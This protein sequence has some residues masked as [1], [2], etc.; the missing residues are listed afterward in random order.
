MFRSTIATTQ[1]TCHIQ[2]CSDTESSWS[3]GPFH[4]VRFRNIHTHR[5]QP[6]P[7]YGTYQLTQLQPSKPLQVMS[8]IHGSPTVDPQPGTNQRRKNTNEKNRAST[9][10]TS[11]TKR[12]TRSRWKRT[13]GESELKRLFS[14]AFFCQSLFNGHPTSFRDWHNDRSNPF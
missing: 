5:P 7:P 12:T 3:V 4:Y 14:P 6:T 9:S 13:S 1:H 11:T 2:A 8:V 10:T